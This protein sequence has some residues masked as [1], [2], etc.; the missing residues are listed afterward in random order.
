LKI[1]K[2]PSSLFFKTWV[3]SKNPVKLTGL[4]F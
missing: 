2:K 4:G 3:Q 1:P